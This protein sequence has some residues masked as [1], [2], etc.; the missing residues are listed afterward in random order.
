MFPLK[1]NPIKKSQS[2]I[3]LV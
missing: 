1:I 3:L 2:L